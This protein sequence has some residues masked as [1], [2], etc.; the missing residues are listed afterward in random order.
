MSNSLL[1]LNAQDQERAIELSIARHE[2]IPIITSH[3]WNPNTCPSSLLPW[4][5]WA[6]SVDEWDVTW[7]E[8]TQRAVIQQ[9]ATVHRHKGTV[10]AVKKALHSLGLHVD[11]V[12]WFDTTN[13]PLLAQIRRPVPHTF[14]FIAWANDH[15]VAATNQPPLLRPDIYSSARRVVAQVKPVRSHFDMWVGAKINCQVGIAALSPGWLQQRRLSQETLPVQIPK[16]QSLLR[17]L[18]HINQRRWCVARF[19]CV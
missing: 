10:G 1:P 18:L 7:S 8:A 3:L 16:S 13:D 12:E 14:A 4:L 6:L 15:A 17:T 2:A 19:Y 5:A 11:F 9:S